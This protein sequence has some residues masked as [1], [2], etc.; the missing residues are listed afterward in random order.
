MSEQNLALARRWVELYNDRSDVAQFLSLLAP[1]VEM[2][3]PRGARLRGREEARTWFEESFDNVRPRIIADQLVGRGSRRSLLLPAMARRGQLQR[4]LQRGPTRHRPGH[5]G[6]R[7]D[8]STGSD[9]LAHARHRGRRRLG[10]LTSEAARSMNRL[11]RSHGALEAR[12]RGAPRMALKPWLDCG[13]LAQA[14][15]GR[16][17]TVIRNLS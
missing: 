14:P 5:A 7:R 10:G 1:D 12:A 11:S 4:L 17:C 8:L 13:R 9:V 6:C 15:A 2:R 16:I 3:T